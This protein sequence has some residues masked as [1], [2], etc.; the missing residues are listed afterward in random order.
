MTT[1]IF[2][3]SGIQHFSKATFRLFQSFIYLIATTILSPNQLLRTEPLIERKKKKKKEGINKLVVNS[4][5]SPI[6]YYIQLRPFCQ[7]QEAIKICCPWLVREK[8]PLT[9]SQIFRDH[10]IWGSW[11]QSFDTAPHLPCHNFIFFQVGFANSLDGAIGSMC[12]ACLFRRTKRLC[13]LGPC[14]KRLVFSGIR[15]SMQN[16]G[17]TPKKRRSFLS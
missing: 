11:S 16:S 2:T 10:E 5:N 9:I 6:V 13:C 7:I 8:L 17:S 4:I 12:G 1:Y 14:R 15:I 3:C